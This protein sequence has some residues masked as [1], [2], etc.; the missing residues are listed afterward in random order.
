MQHQPAHW[1]MASSETKDLFVRQQFP[2][3]QDYLHA[4]KRYN[5]KIRVALG[6]RTQ[7]RCIQKLEEPH[8]CTSARMTQDHHKLDAKTIYNY[9]MSVVK[10]MRTIQES[11]I[12]V[13]I[14][15]SYVLQARNIDAENE[16]ETTEAV[17]GRICVHGAFVE[18]VYWL[19]LMVLISDRGSEVPLPESELISDKRLRRKPKELSVT[20]G[21]SVHIKTTIPDNPQGWRVYKN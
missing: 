15:L 7:Q 1:L 2:N 18:M 20:I 5:M 8:T 4:I 11:I 14:F 13:E 21:T 6:Q 12:I 19:S 10:D 16:T 17:G 3:K 9:T